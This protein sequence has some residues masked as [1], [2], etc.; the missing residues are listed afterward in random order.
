MFSRY[1]PD[2]RRNDVLARVYEL[3]GLRPPK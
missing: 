3:T 2:V 1:L